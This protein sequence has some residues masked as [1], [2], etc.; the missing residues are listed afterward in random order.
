MFEK[1]VSGRT[2]VSSEE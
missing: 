2:I 1:K